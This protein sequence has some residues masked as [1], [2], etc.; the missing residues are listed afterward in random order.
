MNSFISILIVNYNGKKWLENCFDSLLSQ[1][2]KNF[3][4]IFVDNASLDESVEFIKNTYNDDRIKIVQSDTNLGFAGGNNLGFKQAK[5]EYIL[6]LNNDTR[7]PIDY[8]E[9]F[10]D[11][12]LEI[13]NA[14][15]VQSKIILM[16]D[17]SK[18]DVCGSYWTDSSFLYHY[19]FWQNQELDKYNKAM[20]FF[21]NKGASMMIRRKVIEEIG[22]FD[23]DFWSYY[24]ETDLCNRMWLAG[25]ECWYYP[26]A[27]LSHAVG[28]TALTLFHNSEIQFHNFKNKLLS[29]LKNFEVGTL[30]EVLPVYFILT[31][32]LSFFWLLQGKGKH[33]LAIYRSI[34]WNITHFPQTLKKRKIV[35]SFRKKTD[36]EIFKQVKQ[37]PKLKYY[38]YFL[39][40]LEK[41]EG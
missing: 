30:I 4:I 19:G 18:L 11:A 22:F 9:K 25:Y 15:S 1:T 32:A 6:L 5:G 8:L 16:S 3:E 27:V 7:A 40:G 10:K 21:S 35:Q 28:G 37:N 41:Y 23:D 36:A 14:G 12:F 26:G 38:Y 13:P 33:F 34:W 2:Y 24:E 39:T 31:I 20:P 17:A 29:F